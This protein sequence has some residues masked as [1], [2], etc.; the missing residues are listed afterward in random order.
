MRLFAPKDTILP[1]IDALNRPVGNGHTYIYTDSTQAEGGKFRVFTDGTSGYFKTQPWPGFSVPQD[2]PLSEV[3]HD[4]IVNMVITDTNGNTFSLGLGG[5]FDGI[6]T[7]SNDYIEFTHPKSY[8]W[9][10]NIVIPL[11]KPVSNDT[12][13]ISLLLVPIGSNVFDDPTKSGTT[14][15]LFTFDAK[16]FDLG[17]ATPVLPV[18]NV[19]LGDEIANEFAYFFSP[20][21]VSNS[22]SLSDSI[23]QGAQNAYN[24]AAQQALQREG[25]GNAKS[26]NV[27]ALGTGNGIVATYD[28]IP[29]QSVTFTT[30]YLPTIFMGSYIK[31]HNL[32]LFSKTTN[33]KD[34]F[35]MIS[36]I[37]HSLLPSQ[38]TEIKAF[39]LY[40]AQQIFG[41]GN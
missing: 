31:I 29:L 6:Y 4:I 21:I 24:Q 1:L 25:L 35:Y 9:P 7:T 38:Q 40:S 3:L 15:S 13:Y 26:V 27:Q 10:E 17:S 41:G 2:M 11:E 5:V 18:S 23:K 36:G 39:M 22:P 28:T 12:R 30:V 8:V 34:V 32:A 33:G 20:A 37:T 16:N 19:K 14:S